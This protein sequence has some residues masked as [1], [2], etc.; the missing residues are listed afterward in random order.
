MTCLETPKLCGKKEKVM[1]TVYDNYSYSN[2]TQTDPL[3]T[4]PAVEPRPKKTR[5]IA[6]LI[7]PSFTESNAIILPILA[8]LSQQ[9]G[10]QWTTWITHRT[11]SKAML[12][13]MGADL[14]RLRIVHIKKTSDARWVVWQAL[15]QGNSHTVVAEQGHWRQDDIKDMELAADTGNCSGIL[16]T[17]HA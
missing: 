16:V 14:S 17:L 4:L 10:Q 2:E 13:Q 15:A 9:S 7:I 11:P 8:S 3:P 6:E 12:E 5:K 1:N